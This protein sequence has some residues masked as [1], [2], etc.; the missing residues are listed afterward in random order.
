[1]ILEPSF[2]IIQWNRKGRKQICL[3]GKFIQVSEIKQILSTN[4]PEITIHKKQLTESQK[5]IPAVTYRKSEELFDLL[6][7]WILVHDA[8]ESC[9]IT[10]EVQKSI[11]QVPDN[12]NKEFLS[13]LD[14]IDCIYMLT[15]S[16]DT[17][18]EGEE[19]RIFP[20]RGIRLYPSAHLMKDLNGLTVKAFLGAVRFNFDIMIMPEGFPCLPMEEHCMGMYVEGQ[21]YHLEMKPDLYEHASDEIEIMD[22]EILARKLYRMIYRT[23]AIIEHVEMLSGSMKAKDTQVLAD[24]TGGAVFLL[25]PI[26]LSKLLFLIDQKKE[27]EQKIYDLDGYIVL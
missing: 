26:M 11:W 17:I 27:F 10:D 16:E 22:T 8:D 18:S 14:K 15:D 5:Q 4:D 23:D 20:E 24:Q 12:E 7:K 1:M 21:W 19:I 9:F 25:Y 6:S 13:V 3:S 2:Q